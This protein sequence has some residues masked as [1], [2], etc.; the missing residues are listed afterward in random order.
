MRPLKLELSA[1]GPFAGAVCLDM[2][3]LGARGLYLITGDTGAGKTTL[4]DAITYALYGEASGGLRTAEMF[5]SKYAQEETPTYVALTFALRGAV[6]RVKRNPEYLR[7]AKRGAGKRTKEPAK[8]E[9][10]YPDGRVLSGVSAVTEALTRELG[11]NKQQFTQIAMIAQ[12]DFL[13]LLTAGTKERIVIFRE[14]FHTEPYQILQERLKQQAGQLYGEIGQAKLQLGRYIQEIACA[15]D[16][17]YSAALSRVRKDDGLGTLS[18]TVELL[19]KIL[20]EDGDA[21][22]AV[23]KEIRAAED[24]IAALDQEIGRL[25]QIEKISRELRL[26]EEKQPEKQA[27]LDTCAATLATAESMNPERENL[28][29]QIQNSVRELELYVQLSAQEQETKRL[30]KACKTAADA[31]HAAHAAADNHHRAQLELTAELETLRGCEAAYERSS[32]VVSGLQEQTRGLQ[33]LQTAIGQVKAQMNRVVQ[34]TRQYQASASDCDR[35]AQLCAALERDYYDGQAGLLAGR[36]KPG[37]PCPV[38]GS[39]VHPAP[40]GNCRNIPTREQVAAAR[41]EYEEK[42]KVR[43]ELSSR[44][45]AAKGQAET[46]FRTLAAAYHDAVAAAGTPEVLQPPPEGCTQDEMIDCIKKISAQ[47]EELIQKLLVQTADARARADLLKSR[48]ARS[49]EL[50]KRL[51]D[52]EQKYQEAIRREAE[53]E[54]ELAV[55]KEKLEQEQKQLARARAGL[56]YPNQAQAEAALRQIK[57][58]KDRLDQAYASAKKDYDAALLR[59]KAGEQ[60]LRDLKRQLSDDSQYLKGAEKDSAVRRLQ[61]QRGIR[62]TE[63]QRL[64]ERQKALNVRMAANGRALQAIEHTRVRLQQTETRWQWVRAL[65]DTANGGI[66]GKERVMLETYVQTAYFD[67]I[68]QRANIRF[69]TMTSGQYELKRSAEAASLRSQSGLEIDVMD[70]YN[71]TV[72]SVRSLS[73][74]ESFKASLALALGLSDE[75]QSQSGGIQI[76]TMFVDEGFGSLDE[77][78]LQQAVYALSGLA[79]SNRL[80]GIISHVGELREKID[81]QIQVTKSQNGG[82]SVRIVV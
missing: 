44:A 15:A 4:F 41:Q 16:S 47:T 31:V 42:T 56:C 76:D 9:L 63:K 19:E 68:L 65:S 72:R 54:K 2:Q 64:Q 5:R 60:R 25:Q 71:A 73:G 27:V 74:G 66:S 7:P 10:I 70:H 20:Q 39:R 21:V 14:L 81:R 3:P 40:A 36:L 67:R 43:S 22:S 82:S 52:C 51:P 80:V 13:K 33:A 35:L 61:E 29:A 17:P 59:V 34:V 18:E 37:E 28:A 38:C 79:D 62:G 49:A 6:Y 46:A 78:S 69:M 12:G 26:A 50:S 55:L 30:Q 24:E 1:F 23:Q 8:A 77:E 32:T 58:Q 11:L 45:G 57:A 75:I 53:R 48:T